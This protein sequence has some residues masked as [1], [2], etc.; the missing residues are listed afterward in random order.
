MKR[1]R[2]EKRKEATAEWKGEMVNRTPE[3]TYYKLNEREK[4]RDGMGE[5]ES[6]R[7]KKE[8]GVA[9]AVRGRKKKENQGEEKRYTEQVQRVRYRKD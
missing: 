6:T 9:I 7:E 3:K 5:E 4:R 2:R 1:A 8:S